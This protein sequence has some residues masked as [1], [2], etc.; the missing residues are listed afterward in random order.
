VAQTVEGTRLQLVEGEYSTNA[1]VV[2]TLM[3]AWQVVQ[4][5]LVKDGTVKDVCLFV[6]NLLRHDLRFSKIL[7]GLPV[8]VNKVADLSD[9]WDEV[10]KDGGVVRLM[11][12]NPEQIQFIEEF[13]K[14]RGSSRK[15]SVFVKIDGGQRYA[16]VPHHPSI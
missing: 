15:W 6:L 16:P 3:E 13:E 2:S 9:L 8:A 12:D 7:Y 1:V 4:G 14:T 11:V 5:G 10:A